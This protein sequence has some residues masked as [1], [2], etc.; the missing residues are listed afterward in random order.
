[1]GEMEM[2]ELQ[3][4]LDNMLNLDKF[5]NLSNLVSALSHFSL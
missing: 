4:K 2:K 3:G 1:M 5:G